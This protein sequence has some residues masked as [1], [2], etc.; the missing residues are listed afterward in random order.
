MLRTVAMKM[1]LLTATALL[2]LLILT[3][4]G[5][6]QMERVYEGANNANVNAVP[7]L[8]ML[9]TLRRSFL[10]LGL[11]L[12]RRLQAADAQAAAQLEQQVE[13]QRK[14]V[15]DA[16]NRYETDGCLGTDCFADNKDKSYL[17]QEKV[18]WARYEAQADAVLAA[19]RR[20]ATAQ[21]HVLLADMDPLAEQV[22]RLVTGHI[23]Y[24]A[25]VATEQTRIAEDIKREALYLTMG[26]GGIMLAAIAALGFYTARS[27]IRQLG[28]EPDQAAA[29][30]SRLAAG[31][32][33][34]EVVLRKG[35]QDSMMARI[36]TMQAT[37]ERL[38][39]RAEEIGRGNLQDEVPLAS[40][41]DRLGRAINDMIR[42]LR[43]GKVQDDRRNWLKD[44]AS[45][46]GGVLTGDLTTE[47]MAE[48]AISMLGHYL[49]AGRAC[50]TCSRS[51]SSSWTSSAAICTRSATTSGPALPWAKA[52]W[53]R[54][55]ANAS[56]S[57][58]PWRPV[59]RHRPLPPAPA[60]PRHAIA[61]R[62]P[63]C[64]NAS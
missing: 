60:A 33:S 15:R 2:G 61:T 32:L 5:R 52:R 14:A 49:E 64:M 1:A 7:S 35:D 23:A 25:Q 46:L 40:A 43:A 4:L 3:V 51:A 55:R 13:T 21:S 27:V 53:G 31:D 62:I 6:Q 45:Q 50:S 12:E 41:Q 17:E 30:M 29:I 63:W 48:A 56:R 16:I 54:W 20:G 10:Q 37:M 38:A 34:G 19:A 58:W 11:G 24:N 44:G 47:E 9:D 39:A 59:I 28:G 8:I 57:C 42:M 18:V 22:T 36:A 26:A